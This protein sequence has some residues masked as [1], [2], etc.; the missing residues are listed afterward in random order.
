VHH[1]QTVT[2]ALYFILVIVLGGTEMETEGV[3]YAERQCRELASQAVGP[4]R[5]CIQHYNLVFDLWGVIWLVSLV[6]LCMFPVGFILYWYR[7]QLEDVF[8][9]AIAGTIKITRHMRKHFA[10]MKTRIGEKI[11][12]AASE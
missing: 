9:S 3:S 12:V 2:L 11:H 6:A 5:D 7:D 8:V 4:W 10:E 1:I